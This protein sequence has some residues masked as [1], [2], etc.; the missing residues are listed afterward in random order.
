MR[1]NL[2]TEAAIVGAS[3]VAVSSAVMYVSKKADPSRKIPIQLWVFGAGALTHL[4][5]EASGGNEKFVQNYVADR[6]VFPYLPRPRG[7]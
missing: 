4:L 2:L 5:W 1:K 3:L 7:A 6:G